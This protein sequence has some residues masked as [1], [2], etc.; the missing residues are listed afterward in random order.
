MPPKTDATTAPSFRRRKH[1][2][3]PAMKAGIG[4]TLCSVLLV[5]LVLLASGV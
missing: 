4:A 2:M 1:S 3:D 5:A